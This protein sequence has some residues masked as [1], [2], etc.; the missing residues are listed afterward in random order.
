MQA[1][2]SGLWGR[3]DRR[4]LKWICSAAVGFAGV[5]SALYARWTEPL[6]ALPFLG[7]VVRG[8]GHAAAEID[9]QGYDLQSTQHDERG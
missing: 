6:G 3:T 7:L 9:R 1:C 5:L 8:I 2:E 4:S